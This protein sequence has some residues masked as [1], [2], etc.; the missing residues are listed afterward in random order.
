[1]NDQE[2]AIELQNQEYINNQ[3]KKYNLADKEIEELK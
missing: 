3:L 2:K 1:M